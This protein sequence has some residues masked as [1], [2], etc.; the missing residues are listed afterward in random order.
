MKVRAL[1][2]RPPVPSAWRS[3]ILLIPALWMALAPSGCSGEDKEAAAIR[4]LVDKEVRAINTR[5]LKLLSE[6]WAQ[7]D[8]ITLFDVP[9]PGRFQGWTIIGRQWKDF[10]DRFSDLHVAIEG[11]RVDVAG[12]VAWATYDWALSGSMGDRPVEDRGQA[13]AIYRRGDEGWRLVHAHYSPAPP[14]PTAAASPAGGSGPPPAAGPSPS[15]ART[16]AATA[17]PSP[18]GTRTPP[19]AAGPSPSGT[20]TPPAAAAGAPASRA[21]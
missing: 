20:R 2:P 21:N 8:R 7:D 17:A 18:S 1:P 6:V 5:D 4:D 19:A 16:P 13:T 9:S 12:D 3:L 15:G 10:F 11:L 14:G